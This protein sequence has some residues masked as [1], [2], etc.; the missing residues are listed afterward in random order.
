MTE[1]QRVH[2]FA[3][4]LLAL[5]QSS[6]ISFDALARRS[7]TSSSTL[8]RYCSGAAVP[9]DFRV[10]EKV[11]RLC[12]AEPARL[13][14]LHRLWILADAERDTPAPAPESEVDAEGPAPAP[15]WRSL[16]RSKKAVSAVALLGAAGPVVLV[17]TH[18]NRDPV[19]A[20]PPAA[21]PPVA[22]PAA[23]C[24]ANSLVT[25]VDGFHDGRVWEADFT[26]PNTKGATLVAMSDLTTPIAVMDYENSWFLCWQA[27]KEP[28]GREKLW[29][30]TR[31]DR[32]MRGAESWDGWGFLAADQVLTPQHPVP[33]MPRC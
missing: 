26:C 23:G 33:G 15:R 16:L 7:G 22:S 27:R 2:E 11:A 10:V 32:M 20:P 25:H 1:I 31:G 19:T 18:L 4:S 12:G 30:Y 29:Y 13:K 24:V 5:K 14:E 21:S 17:S 8:H 3:Q 9:G 28:G 6:G